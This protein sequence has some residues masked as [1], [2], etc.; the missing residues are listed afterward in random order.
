M[1]QVSGVLEGCR[2]VEA[3]LKGFP[4]QRAGRSVVPAL[5]LIDVGEVFA[6]FLPRDAP[7]EFAIGS[8]AMELTI[9][10]DVA[11]FPSCKPLYSV[12]IVGKVVVPQVSD[13]VGHP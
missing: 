3:L 12:I 4:D 7:Q 1:D 8:P 9:D 13:E 11:F 5:A 6:A 10:Q 2:L